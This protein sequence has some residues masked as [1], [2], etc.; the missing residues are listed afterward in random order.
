MIDLYFYIDRKREEKIK[1]PVEVIWVEH[2]EF[3]ARFVRLS[4]QESKQL[5][6]FLRV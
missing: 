6:F 1:E 3:G 4:H 2:K 5:G